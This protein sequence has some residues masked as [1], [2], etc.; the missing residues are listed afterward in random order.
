MA[1]VGEMK[2]ASKKN[3]YRTRYLD[4]VHKL[5]ELAILILSTS[6]ERLWKALVSTL[7]Q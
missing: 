6:T 2:R 5:S 4:R 3:K 1:N 7:S